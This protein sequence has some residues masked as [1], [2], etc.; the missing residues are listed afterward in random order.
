MRGEG[1]AFKATLHRFHNWRKKKARAEN[2]ERHCW[3]HDRIGTGVDSCNTWLL[4]YSSG[5]NLCNRTIL[6][7][8]INMPLHLCWRR[9][10]CEPC[11]PPALSRIAL[12]ASPETQP[13]IKEAKDL[14]HRMPLNPETLTPHA[15]TSSYTSRCG[16]GHLPKTPS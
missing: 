3:R 7:T 15:H 2:S 14:L 4:G 1:K 9:L 16:G 8:T 10:N 5:P 11:H 6:R 13:K 12:L